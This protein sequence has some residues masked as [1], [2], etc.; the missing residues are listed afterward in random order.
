MTRP[1]TPHTSFFAV[2]RI[3]TQLSGCEFAAPIVGRTASCVRDWGNDQTTSCP[4]WA[5][6][7]ALDA[8]YRAAGGEGAPLFEA[9]AAQL[10]LAF[11]HLVACQKELARDLAEASREVGEALGAAALLIV[12]GCTPG[13]VQ[14]AVIEI[15]QAE[16]RLARMRRR[17]TSFIKPGA[18]PGHRGGGK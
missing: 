8:A 13:Q 10:D 15:D 9:Y 16:T 3:I 11:N 12:P 5:Q 6:A 2:Q 7:I 18:G 14:T 4:S 1:R 17:V